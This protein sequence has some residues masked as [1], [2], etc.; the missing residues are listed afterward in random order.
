L[1]YCIYCF[2][3]TED[4]F[5]GETEL[6]LINEIQLPEFEIYNK[7]EDENGVW[8]YSVTPVKDPERCPYCGSKMIVKNGSVDRFVRDLPLYEHPV[9]IT[10]STNRYR[11]N[12]E[13]C[14][15]SFTPSFES[16]EDRDKITKRMKDVIKERCFQTGMTDLAES[17][18]VSVATIDRI[19]KE[20]IEERESDWTY[21]VPRVL[22]LAETVIGK[23]SRLICVDVENNGVVDILEDSSP[24]ALRKFLKPAQ[25]DEFQ[26]GFVIDFN[27]DYKSVIKEMFPRSFI[28]VDQFF[29]TRDILLAAGADIGRLGNRELRN[30]ILKNSEELSEEEEEKLR[31]LFRK[32]PRLEGLYEAKEQLYSMYDCDSWKQ[33]EKAFEEARDIAPK[34][35]RNMQDLLSKIRK[36][37]I[38][39]TRFVDHRDEIKSC[40]PLAIKLAKQVE[41]NGAGYSFKSLRAR[42]LFGSYKK[43]ARVTIRKPVYKKSSDQSSNIYKHAGLLFPEDLIDHYEEKEKVLGNYVEIGSA[44]E[45]FW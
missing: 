6:K 42:L 9:A 12:N 2:T 28:I 43:E 31:K 30:A 13:G 38:E 32:T 41:K 24:E 23:K 20:S 26:H 17:M 36:F 16:V 37:E 18:G 11:C 19:I 27:E 39:V 25:K 14:G 33:A 35:C 10:I 5:T 45:F 29:V 21:Y 34:D 15:R 40:I 4:V 22:G 1:L 3:L 8:Y 44:M 7:K